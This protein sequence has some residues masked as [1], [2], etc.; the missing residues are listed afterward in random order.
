[1]CATFGKINIPHWER[2]EISRHERDRSPEPILCARCF[3]EDEPGHRDCKNRLQ[4]LD[5]EDDAKR[6]EIYF[7]KRGREKERAKDARE[8]CD[9]AERV[10]FFPF[11]LFCFPEF[12]KE[13][14]NEDEADEML[15][16]DDG[17][18]WKPVE[19]AAQY[20]I[21]PPQDGGDKD[22]ERTVVHEGNYT[23]E[24]PSVSEL[25][26]GACL[27]RLLKGWHTGEKPEDIVLFPAFPLYHARIKAHTFADQEEV[28]GEKIS[29]VRFEQ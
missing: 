22:K 25:T 21:E 7:E 4:L 8:E 15:E 9:N 27:P 23:K 10:P 13:W 12:K 28:G 24:N 29:L 5:K 26:E 3:F 2:D 16:K 1:V 11:E 19:R 17:D 18:G 14:R 20:A 6:N